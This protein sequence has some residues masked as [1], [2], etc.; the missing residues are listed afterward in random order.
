VLVRVR[1]WGKK[2]LQAFAKNSWH[3][4]YGRNPGLTSLYA[5]GIGLIWNDW[6]FI[7]EPIQNIFTLPEIGKS[8]PVVI[9]YLAEYSTETWPFIANACELDRDE[10]RCGGVI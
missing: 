9:G 8:F 3:K 4:N 10:N 1:K 6:T 2:V 7:G 5:A